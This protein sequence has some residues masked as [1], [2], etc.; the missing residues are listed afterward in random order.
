MAG[1]PGQTYSHNILA[2]TGND[3]E[4]RKESNR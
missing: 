2:I 1:R 4:Y 3:S